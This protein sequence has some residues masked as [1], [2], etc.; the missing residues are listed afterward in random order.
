MNVDNSIKYP[1]RGSL[2]IIIII[3]VVVMKLNLER[4]Y[5][6]VFLVTQ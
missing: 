4:D 5:G 1:L 3:I 2:I 6:N